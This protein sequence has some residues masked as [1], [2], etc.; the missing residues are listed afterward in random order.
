MLFAPRRGLAALMLAALL[1]T[2][3]APVMAE[4]PKTLEPGKLIVGME[5]AYPPFET[6]DEQGVPQGISPDFARDLAQSLNLELVIENLPWDG[7]I[8][9]LLTGKVDMVVSSMTITEP[10]REQ[11]DFSEPY[12]NAYLALLTNKESGIEKAEDL[13][14]PGRKVAVKIGSTGY[15]YA[16]KNLSQAEI[17]SF[18]DESAC[19]TE[20][21][22]GKADAFIY[23][24]LTIYRNWQQHQ[25]STQPV[26]IPFQD[27]ENWGAAFNKGHEDLVAA[28]NAFI[29]QY[30]KEGG[31][32]K[33]TQKHLSEEKKV[34]DELGFKWFFDLDAAQQAP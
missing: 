24:Q 32:E 1:L 11:V 8:P 2:S 3:L 10:R 26:F 22:Q 17:L 15:Y 12:A 14:Q 7:L 34:F 25:D 13:N 19:V 30:T 33:L 6:S 5:L 20:V 9:A 31:F 28:V 29:R 4:A 21:V 27:V 18:P 23:D 16:Q